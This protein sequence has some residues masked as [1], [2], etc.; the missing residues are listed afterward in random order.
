M[1]LIVIYRSGNKAKNPAYNF[2][3]TGLKPRKSTLL[4]P[5]KIKFSLPQHSDCSLLSHIDPDGAHTDDSVFICFPSVELVLQYSCNA[6]PRGSLP[7]FAWDDVATPIRPIT[8]RHS[9]SLRSCAHTS[10][11]VPYGSIAR[12]NRAE[13]WGF[14]VSRNEH[15]NELGLIFP[16]T[17]V[18]DRVKVK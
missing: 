4:Y 13:V 16:P 3:R 18:V 11:V 1:P 6:R 10:K 2:H 8:G 9:L 5:V 17:G 15:A 12:H 7:A 14:R